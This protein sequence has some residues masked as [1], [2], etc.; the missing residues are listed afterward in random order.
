MSNTVV[1][2]LA[3]TIYAKR[4]AERRK[5]ADINK[6]ISLQLNLVVFICQFVQYRETDPDIHLV[7]VL[8]YF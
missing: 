7:A 6:N 4:G 8:K 2:S 3:R 5:S 1:N